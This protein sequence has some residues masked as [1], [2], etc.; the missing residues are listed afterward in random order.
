M[1]SEYEFDLVTTDGI[2]ANGGICGGCLFYDKA[3]R[4]LSPCG[5]MN[6]SVK[7]GDVK[8]LVAQYVLVHKVSGIPLTSGE[9]ENMYTNHKI[10]HDKFFIVG[11]SNVPHVS[12]GKDSS[13]V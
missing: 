1:S 2:Y 12:H 9:V 13:T 5:L 11:G 7:I 6:H 10:E 8:C 3:G 4:L